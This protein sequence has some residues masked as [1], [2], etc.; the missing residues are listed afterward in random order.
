MSVYGQLLTDSAIQADVISTLQAENTRLVE[1]LREIKSKI[2][3]LKVELDEVIS[4]CEEFKGML[5]AREQ[6]QMKP[7]VVRGFIRV[8]KNSQR[9]ECKLKWRLAEAAYEGYRAH[10]GGKSLATG[11]LIPAWDELRNEIK[12]A[13]LASITAVWAV[14]ADEI[15]I[16]IENAGSRVR[17]RLLNR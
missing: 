2:A 17:E 13:W 3:A 5:T 6:I 15:S 10:T 8:G 11:Q 4:C 7:P 12:D 9:G 14:L 16:E 1:E